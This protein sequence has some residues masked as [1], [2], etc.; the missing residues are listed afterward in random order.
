VTVFIAL[1]FNQRRCLQ[2]KEDRPTVGDSAFLA[3][4]MPN[5]V[6]AKFML[7]AAWFCIAIGLLAGLSALQD[8][9]FSAYAHSHWPV[10]KGD[11]LSYEQKS[12]ERAGSS[13][14]DVYWIEFHVEF[15]PGKLGC[16]TGSYWGVPK[17]FSCIGSIKTLSTSSWTSAQQW[18]KQHPRNSATS[19]LYD[20]PSGRLRFADESVGNVVPPENLIVLLVAGGA[21]LLLLIAVQR[22]M[23]FLKTMPEDC[24][25]TPRESADKS[26]PNDLTDLNL[27]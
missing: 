24:D 6:R 9:A 3:Q 1:D 15:D 17:A 26:G 27:S 16:T 12:G 20:P 21:G 22:R 23:R 18:I 2:V 25:D 8:I 5:R 4:L 10:V 7:F 19:F 11:I 14:H 13:T